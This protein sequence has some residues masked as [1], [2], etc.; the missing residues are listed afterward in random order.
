MRVPRSE[1]YAGRALLVVLMAIIILP[2]ISIFLT[3]LHPSGSLPSGLDWRA[4]PQWGNFVEAF[5]VA[6]MTA[7]LASSIF[8]VVMVVPIS[9]VISTM[10]GFAIGL[11]RIPGGRLLLLLF[12]FGLTLPF[13]GIIT[14]L[15]YIVRQMGLLNTRLAIV[16][17]LIALFMPFM[18]WR[19]KKVSLPTPS[20]QR[21]RLIGRLTT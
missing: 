12:I 15:Y 17:P 1:L 8:I 13:E 10:A 20:G 16:L 4:D 3:A 5:E 21:T 9:L 6:N 11:L 18:P 19:W 14:P 2:F 7:L